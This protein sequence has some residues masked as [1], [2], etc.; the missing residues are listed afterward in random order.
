MLVAIDGD[1]LRQEM[2][3]RGLDGRQVAALAQVTPATV[4]HALNH[5]RVGLNT[6]RA[7]ARVL[8]TTPP[9]EGAGFV[10]S[11][12][13]GL[14]EVAAR[15]GCPRPTENTTLEAQQNAQ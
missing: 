3:R 15:P 9:L 6:V 4:S 12:G 7:L 5:R 8:A 13:Q 1:R 11:G 14:A 2:A 10:T